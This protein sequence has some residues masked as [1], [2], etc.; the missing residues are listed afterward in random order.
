MQVF[1]YSR[2][3]CGGLFKYW[4][5]ICTKETS[6]SY[7]TPLSG[8]NKIQVLHNDSFVHSKGTLPNLT[9]VSIR[10]NQLNKIEINAFQGLHLRM[11]D[12]Y[13]NSLKFRNS[14]AKSAFAPISQ[15]LE[16]LDIRRNLLGDI[17]KMDYPVSVGELVNL[18]ELRI[19]CLRNKSFPSEYSKLKNL[20]KL[21]FTGGRKTSSICW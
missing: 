2:H 4:T 18:K 17:S 8:Q 7:N 5:R 15:S 21:S 20:I 19:D 10:S 1:S 3:F 12:L 11:L 9:M 14:H 13:N 16:V 6:I